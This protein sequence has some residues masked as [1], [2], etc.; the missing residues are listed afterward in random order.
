MQRFISHQLI[1]SIYPPPSR[2]PS[3]FNPTDF[4]TFS[5]D[6]YLSTADA[7]STYAKLAGGQTIVAQETFSGGIKSDTIVPAT[8]GGTVTITG[9][10]SQTGDLTISGNVTQNSGYS[11]S[12]RTTTINGTA[13]VTRLLQSGST[14]EN[15]FAGNCSFSNNLIQGSLTTFA[16]SFGTAATTHTITS[17]QLSWLGNNNWSGELKL[18]ADDSSANAGISIVYLHKPSSTLFLTQGYKSTSMTTFTTAVASTTSLTVTLT[19]SCRLC[20]I[21]T[22][23]T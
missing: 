21:F 15:S 11:T 23:A 14:S 20:W 5:T 1:M 17:T 7:N 4:S 12:L 16:T 13:T 2:Y 19:N 9:N 8:T 10:S 3:I 22:G 6:T 18:F